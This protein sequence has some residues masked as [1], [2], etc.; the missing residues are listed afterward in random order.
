MNRTTKINI[1]AYASE[2]DKS[3]KYEGDLVEYNGKRYWVSLMNETVEFVGEIT[4]RYLFE[5]ALREK[6]EET[7]NAVEAWGRLND[8][9]PEEIQEIMDRNLRREG[10]VLEKEK[11]NGKV[12]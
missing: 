7:A 3:Y 11:E 5:K 1:L 10:V 4:E 6:E 9:S 8:I 2:P 12:I